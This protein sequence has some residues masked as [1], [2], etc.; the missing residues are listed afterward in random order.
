M[1][2]TSVQI[3]SAIF[4]VRPKHFRFNEQT[5][6]S[7]TFQERDGH[8]SAENISNKARQ[9]FDMLAKQLQD[10]GVNTYIFDEAPNANTPDA[11]FPNN[12]ISFHPDGRVVFY[13]MLAPNRRLERRQDIVE[14][15]ARDFEVLEII[16]FSIY[17][18]KGKFLE[19]TGSIVFDHVHKVAYANSSPRTSIE[20]FRLCCAH[21][22][23]KPILFH[24]IDRQGLA[25]YHTNVMMNLGDDFAIVCLEAM[26]PSD[27]KL[28]VHSLEETGHEI[29]AISVDQM[30][31]FAGN[32]I[33]LAGTMGKILLMSSSAFQ[34]LTTAQVRQLE[35]SN[36]LL[37]PGLSTIERYGGGSARCMVAGIHLPKL[38]R[39][40]R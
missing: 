6:A 23:Y 14:H 30:E 25:I 35:K 33:Q 37:H 12:W 15:I 9:E 10:A 11:V 1:E 36:Q 7:N 3:P 8:V 22:G 32:M 16:D 26:P 29:V 39:P 38:L 28:V 40:K 34:S 13:P 21:L 19:G 4:M 18:S 20:L 31:Y 2:N 17:E 27:A 24:A 5:A